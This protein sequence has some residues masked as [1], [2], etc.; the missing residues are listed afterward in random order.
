M[1]IRNA[2]SSVLRTDMLLRTL[3][4]G[5]SFYY[6]DSRKLSTSESSA[7]WLYESLFLPCVLGVRAVRLSL[8]VVVGVIIGCR[9]VDCSPFSALRRLSLML[10]LVLLSYVVAL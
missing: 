8:M 6:S 1:W 9:S 7:C 2:D 3:H 5:W 4:N 10:W